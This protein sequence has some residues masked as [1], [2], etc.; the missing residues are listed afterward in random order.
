MV[1]NLKKLDKTNRSGLDQIYKY[2]YKCS[3]CHNKYG[4]D[5]K[6]E[7]R[8]FCPIHDLKFRDNKFRNIVRIRSSEGNQ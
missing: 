2:T 7:A 5:Y 1:V 3:I 6:E 8:H 4:S